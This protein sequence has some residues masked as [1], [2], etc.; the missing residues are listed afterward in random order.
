MADQAMTEAYRNADSG[1][2]SLIAV[3]FALLAL[4]SVFFIL[5]LLSRY[6]NESAFRPLMFWL[7]IAAYIFN[8]ANAIDNA[9]TSTPP[10]TN[11]GRIC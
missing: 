8:A 2:K 10:L 4:T 7:I 11:K 9:C 6:Y 1:S 5:F 3:S